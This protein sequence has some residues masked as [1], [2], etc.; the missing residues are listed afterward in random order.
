MNARTLALACIVI[1]VGSMLLWFSLGP[2]DPGGSAALSPRES[3]AQESSAGDESELSRVP[4]ALR[5]REETVEPEP[6][7]SLGWTTRVPEDDGVTGWELAPL[8]VQVIDSLSGERVPFL[9]FTARD[10]RG[11]T[12][13]G[14]TDADGRVRSYEKLSVGKVHVVLTIG[15]HA[16]D[17]AFG[18]TPTVRRGAV[19]EQPKLAHAG[20]PNEPDVW[21]IKAQRLVP[22]RIDLPEPLLDHVEIWLTSAAYEGERRKIPLRTTHL[23]N[24]P[25]DQLRGATHV[26]QLESVTMFQIQPGHMAIGA[27]GHDLTDWKQERAGQRLVTRKLV[28]V[29]AADGEL[30]VASTVAPELPLLGEAPIQLTPTPA[31]SGTLPAPFLQAWYATELELQAAAIA[32]SEPGKNYRLS[33]VVTS[34]SG[35]FKEAVFVRANPAGDPAIHGAQRRKQWIT[36]TWTRGPDGRWSAPFELDELDAGPYR[37]TAIT[38]GGAKVSGSPFSADPSVAEPPALSFNVL[39]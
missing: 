32:A 1:L 29:V 13:A 8:N 20:N 3:L 21:E 5:K 38:E 23:K 7:D 10:E 35:E 18:G 16:D 24:A 37:I 39:D 31:T 9:S 26:I 15:A 6:S 25:M 19:L 14:C 12:L 22:F 36:A 27:P 2:P 11:E 28:A 33:G 30:L 4:Q 34:D 17:L